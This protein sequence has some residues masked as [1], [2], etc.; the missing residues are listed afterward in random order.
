[1][2]VDSVCDHR[3]RSLPAGTYSKVGPAVVVP[4]SV[5]ISISIWAWA[6][7]RHIEPIAVLSAS[8]LPL[9][10]WCSARKSAQW[11]SLNCSGARRIAVPGAWSLVRGLRRIGRI[12]LQSIAIASPVGPDCGGAPP[13]HHAPT[14]YTPHT[15]YSAPCPP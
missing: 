8:G 3:G 4:S 11:D 6:L 13:P 1:S 14:L 12:P 10:T 2:S 7:R 5:G 9:N 15:Q